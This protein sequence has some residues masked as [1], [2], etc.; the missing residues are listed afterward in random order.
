MV[1]LDLLL[2]SVVD[3]E[4]TDEARQFVILNHLYRKYENCSETTVRERFLPTLRPIN[5]TRN[6]Y[7]ILQKKK[8][9]I[10]Y[11]VDI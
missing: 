4:Y 7:A 10:L 11:I 5:R 3:F 9:S 6:S 1:K 2:A 8:K